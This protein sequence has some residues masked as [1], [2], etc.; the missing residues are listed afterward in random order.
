MMSVRSSAESRG[1]AQVTEDQRVRVTEADFSI[2]V[3]MTSYG[4]IEKS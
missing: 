1:D 2:S 4:F 3:E